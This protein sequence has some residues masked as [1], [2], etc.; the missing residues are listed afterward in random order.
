MG[1][2]G[3]LLGEG[4]RHLVQDALARQDAAVG[5]G[6]QVGGRPAAVGEFT[7]SWPPGRVG[8]LEQVGV[9][10]GV[11]GGEG[12]AGPG[13]AGHFG[14]G[15]ALGER[16][17]HRVDLAALE[18]DAPAVV[19][20]PLGEF[21]HPG[22]GQQGALDHEVGEQSVGDAFLEQ[23]LGAGGLQHVG[24]YLV[25]RCALGQPPGDVL[26][27]FRVA[28][29]VDE[30]VAA[31]GADGVAGRRSGRVD[32]EVLLGGAGG[33]GDE[34]CLVGERGQQPGGLL[35]HEGERLV[36]VRL[37]AQQPWGARVRHGQ[38]QGGRRV[39]ECSV[40]VAGD[41]GAAVRPGGRGAGHRAAFPSA[42][43]APR[44]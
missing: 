34:Q 33:G 11:A 38:F 17:R 26:P 24:A 29:P 16:V 1:R 14:D 18:G 37:D 39:D 7:V 28:L 40:Q 42:P 44:V 21:L 15:G 41:E 9:Q 27:P 23:P 22:A 31:V 19:A 43:V 4:R 8:V 13:S 2:G 25:E 35:R 10:E 36:L 20:G 3:G 12:A 32:A 6:P 30:E 5:K